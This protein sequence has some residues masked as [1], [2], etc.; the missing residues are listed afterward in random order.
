MES[1]TFEYSDLAASVCWAESGYL[2]VKEAY[3]LTF[4]LLRVERR[5]LTSSS[6]PLPR[7]TTSQVSD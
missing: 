3:A 6:Y 5:C 1:G 7:R 2:I 4:G